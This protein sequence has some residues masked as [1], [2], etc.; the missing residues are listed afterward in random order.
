M[1]LRSAAFVL[2]LLTFASGALAQGLCQVRLSGVMAPKGHLVEVEIGTEAFPEG[3]ILH[4][5]LASGTT[6]A[7]LADLIAS[8]LERAEVG[9]KLSKVGDH[10][11]SLWIDGVTFVNLRLGAGLRGQISC[12]E[13]P[14]ASLRVLPASAIKGTTGLVAT[15]S[16]A[17]IVQGRAPIR[18]Q[19]HIEADLTEA[20]EAAKAATAIWKAA[21]EGWVSERPGSDS[22]RPIK[23]KGGGIFTGF[24]A[25]LSGVSDARLEITL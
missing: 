24:S 11:A 6:G 7:E 16:T 18:S 15:A 8:R 20:D 13:G 12:T 2:A 4:V 25:G 21:A 17:I 5:H 1:L 3:I 9:A 22:W 10:A 19:L 14:P 23:P